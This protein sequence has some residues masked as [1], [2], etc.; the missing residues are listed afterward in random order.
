L[1]QDDLWQQIGRTRAS[2]RS[3]QCES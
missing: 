2:A 3:R 1:V